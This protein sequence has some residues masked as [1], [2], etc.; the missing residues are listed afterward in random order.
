[1]QQKS[2]LRATV[3]IW[4][5]VPVCNSITLKL[6]RQAPKSPDQLMQPF[7]SRQQLRGRDVCHDTV[8]T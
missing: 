3:T 5:L 4:L 2:I 8:Q 6:H 1:M 7:A